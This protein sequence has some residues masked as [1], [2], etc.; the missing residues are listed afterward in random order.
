MQ[1]KRFAAALLA[2]ATAFAL[3]ACGSGSAAPGA[4]GGAAKP[5]AGKTVFRLAFNQTEQHPQYKAAVNLGKK[6]S[7]KTEGRYSIEV[8]ANETL[9]TQSDVVNNVSDGSV[10]M[11]YIGGPVMES[12][13]KDFIVFN[14]PFMFDSQE[15]Q[16]A[17]F[18]DDAVMGDL[19][20]SIEGSKKITVLGALH[21][22]TRNVY[23]KKA[24][25]TPADMSGLKIRVQQSD[26]QV[27]MIQAMGGI[28]SPMG[29]GEVYT[30]LQS[31]VLDG[32]ENNETVYNALKH[33]EVAKFYSYT[34]HLAIPDYLLMSTQSLEKMS[35]ADRKALMDLLPETIKEA[36]DG[37]LTFAKESRAAS[38]KNG[39]TF[40]EDVDVAAFKAAV[41][42]LV[43][44][45]INN[46]V[47]KKLYDAVQKA[48]KEHPAK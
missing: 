46:D 34:K 18:A 47:R 9:G 41:Q 15:A 21:A 40:V 12:F 33:D 2:G 5:A 30:A 45:S 22:G 25:K 44:E 27:K 16:A 13:N 8:F 4:S 6:L 26:S 37:F 23:T 7:E 36:N 1:T 29:Q 35:E 19:K 38:E 20:K 42:P 3:A 24:V 17:V 32:A 48:N 14:L 31:G 28:A 39:A 10:D 11:M 43:T